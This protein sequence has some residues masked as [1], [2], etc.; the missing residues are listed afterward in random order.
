MQLNELSRM[1]F[2]ATS[3]INEVTTEL[4]ENL[5]DKDGTPIED[6][7]KVKLLVDAYVKRV[8]IEA[9]L[10]R[11]AVKQHNEGF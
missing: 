3:F 2:I 8:R 10:I 11:S 1:Y 6:P 7:D 5:H 4:Y 9:E